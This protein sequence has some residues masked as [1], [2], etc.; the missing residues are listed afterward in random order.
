MR[1]RGYLWLV[2][3]SRSDRSQPLIVTLAFS[4]CIGFHTFMLLKTACF[5]FLIRGCYLPQRSCWFRF[6]VNHNLHICWVSTSSGNSTSKLRFSEFLCNSKLFALDAFRIEM[7]L[8][9]N[10]SDLCLA[11]NSILLYCNGKNQD[12]SLHL[13]Q[14]YRFIGVL[15]LAWS[16]KLVLTFTCAG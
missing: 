8:R 10:I 14:G 12:L 7:D 13:F 15:S 11:V 4:S 1:F 16:Q 5:N 2:L 9:S 6:A 3:S